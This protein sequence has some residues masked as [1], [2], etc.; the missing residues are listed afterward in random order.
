M[1]NKINL[2][3]LQTQKERISKRVN[4]RMDA[5]LALRHLKRTQGSA[6]QINPPTHTIKL[7]AGADARERAGWECDAAPPRVAQAAA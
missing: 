3:D 6:P 5:V 4:E 7:A 1:T 2:F